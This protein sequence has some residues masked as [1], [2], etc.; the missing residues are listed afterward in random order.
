MSPPQ[1]ADAN[2][3]REPAQSPQSIDQPSHPAETPHP[4]W[5]RGKVN[6][7]ATLAYFRRITSLFGRERQCSSIAKSNTAELGRP[8]PKLPPNCCAL[9]EMLIEN[10]DQSVTSREI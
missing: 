10:E 3:P 2:Q 8:E 6:L 1:P 9:P 7:P 4:A 5:C